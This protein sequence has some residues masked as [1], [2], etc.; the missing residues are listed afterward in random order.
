MVKTKEHSEDV[1]K[2]V[3]ECQVNGKDYDKIFQRLNIPKSTFRVISKRHNS[4]G[5]VKNVI[6]RGRKRIL[7][8]RA[9][10][11]IHR[12]VNQNPKVTAKEDGEARAPLE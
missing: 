12:Y 1:K 8:P 10:R 6:G 3:I 11:N 5:H 9:E 4:Q 2:R 7:S